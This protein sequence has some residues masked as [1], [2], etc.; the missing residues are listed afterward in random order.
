MKHRISRTLGIIERLY[1]EL[2]NNFLIN[3]KV[4][5]ENKFI[6]LDHYLKFDLIQEKETTRYLNLS[7]SH[8][9]LSL[10]KK[11]FLNEGEKTLRKKISTKEK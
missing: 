1:A 7:Q 10:L 2:S 3:K 9:G 11:L 5:K 6:Y 8:L 4:K